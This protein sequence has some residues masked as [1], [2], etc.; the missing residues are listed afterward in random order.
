MQANGGEAY[1]VI[2]D[3]AD[4]IAEDAADVAIIKSVDTLLREH[5]ANT[6][7]GVANTIFAL[8]LSRAIKRTAVA[9]KRWGF[10]PRGRQKFGRPFFH[11][12]LCRKREMARSLCFEPKDQI[13]AKCQSS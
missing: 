13:P 6:L 4:P 11:N 2:V 7:S 5:N 10:P 3:I 9:P 8:E 12:L 1:N